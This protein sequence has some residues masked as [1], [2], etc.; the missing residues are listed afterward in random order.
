[1]AAYEFYWRDGTGGYHLI[2]LLPERRRDPIRITRES[3]MNW[4]RI[5]AGDALDVTN[6]CFIQVEV[7]KEILAN[8][9]LQGVVKKVKKQ[10]LHPSYYANLWDCS[11]IGSVQEQLSSTNVIHETEVRSLSAPPRTIPT[12]VLYIFNRRRF[13]W[14]TLSSPLRQFFWFLLLWQPVLAFNEDQGRMLSGDNADSKNIFFK[15]VTIDDIIGRIL[16]VNLPF[17]NHSIIIRK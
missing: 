17:N 13:K 2:G 3:I 10:V 14:S 11:A 16:W 5:V 12:C 4:R 6:L 15:R 8:S 7:Q 9:I 1:M